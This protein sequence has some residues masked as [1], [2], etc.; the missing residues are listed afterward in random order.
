MIE[1]YICNLLI[2]LFTIINCIY[3]LHIYKIVCFVFRIFVSG[4]S[5]RFKKITIIDPL[6]KLLNVVIKQ[7]NSLCESHKSCEHSFCRSR[8]SVGVSMPLKIHI[9]PVTHVYKLRALNIN[10]NL[11]LFLSLR[12]ELCSVL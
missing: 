7:F 12:I 8:Y 9:F 5:I 3:K 4:Q 11:S 1:R 6:K 2:V 10:I